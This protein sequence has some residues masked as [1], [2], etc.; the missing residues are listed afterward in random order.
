MKDQIVRFM[1]KD[2]FIKVVA[3]RSTETVERGRV[4]HQTLPTAT[5]ALGRTLSAASMMGN[6]QKV[7]NGSLTLQIKGDGPLGTILAVSDSDGNVRG[8]VTNPQ[9]SLLEKYKGKLDV[10]TA[11]G[12]GMLTVIRDMQMKEPYIGSVEL[13]TGEIAEDITSYFAQ[14]EQI[15]TACALGV[16]VDVDQSVK[17]A[18]GYI[19]QLLPGAPDDVIDRVEGAVFTADSVTE[20][21]SENTDLTVMMKT[22]L[23]GFDLQLLETTDIEYRCYCSSERVT[24]TLV[25]L[26]KKE[27]ESIVEDGETIH[28]GCQFCDYDYKF[29][30]EDVS[31]ILE[32][33]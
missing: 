8:L 32:T 7:D 16:L 2:G 19:I 20:M 24:S 15:P 31:K 25:T 13:E 22:V 3:I 17:V 18:G 29:T 33:L 9:V 26:G 30:P 23:V 4:I 5:A 28:I 11:V 10:G 21:L 1:S 14:S 6:M 12:N 27:L